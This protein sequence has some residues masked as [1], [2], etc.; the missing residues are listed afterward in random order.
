MAGGP[1]EDYMRNGISDGSAAV[2]LLEAVRVGANK[3]LLGNVVRAM[4][5]DSGPQPFVEMSMVLVAERDGEVVGAVYSLPP[6]NFI[7]QILDAGVDP[8]HALMCAL[9]AAKVKALAVDPAAAGAG[10]ASALL[11]AAVQVY[12]RAGFH[13]VYG[14]FNVGSGLERFYAARS[15]EIL[16]AGTG[17]PMY[18]ILGSPAMLAAD[19]G[20][21]MF[22]RWR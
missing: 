4:T 13:L 8:S 11:R 7:S 20:E 6:M 17:V 22:A 10:I 18:A 19:P 15:F 1:L 9:A 16:P 12:D 5:S 2:A 21:Q 3:P 14:S